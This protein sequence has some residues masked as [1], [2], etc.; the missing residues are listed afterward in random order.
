[1]NT[2][3]EEPFILAFVR[4]IRRPLALEKGGGFIF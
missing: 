4:A 3:F 2:P 1:M